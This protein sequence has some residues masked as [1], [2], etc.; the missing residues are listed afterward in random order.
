MT[1]SF[2]L[3]L[4][5]NQKGVS[6][7]KVS[8]RLSSQKTPPSSSNENLRDIETPEE[9]SVQLHRSTSSTTSDPL[10]DDALS[11]QY[12]SSPNNA[13]NSYSS[14]F[15]LLLKDSEQREKL[16]NILNTDHTEILEKWYETLKQENHN[17]KLTEIHLET[18]LSAIQENIR[19]T[20]SNDPVV[21]IAA[22]LRKELE[23]DSST[24]IDIQRSF[25]LLQEIVTT[26]LKCHKIQPHWVFAFDNFLREAIT[27]TSLL[28]TPGS[29]SAAESL[30]TPAT[31]TKSASCI[32]RSTS[33]NEAVQ[34][35]RD[36]IQ[37]LLKQLLDTLSSLHQTFIDWKMQ[38]EKHNSANSVGKLL[39]PSVAVDPQLVK[40][41]KQ[42]QVDEDTIKH[43]TYEEYSYI[44]FV[45]MVTLEELHGLNIKKGVVYRI[46]RSLTLLRKA[47]K[48]NSSSHGE[49]TTSVCGAENLDVDHKYDGS[50]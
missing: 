43:I 14:K 37:K 39:S 18:L 29:A 24:L 10:R 5:P 40:W 35:M 44:D 21:E 23:L 27:S 32:L 22:E 50:S 38:Q 3:F 12:P 19:C 33:T 26:R 6:W 28:L 16:L 7:N 34:Q 42:C 15:Y 30:S 17:T 1:F 48:I 2:S 45:E 20:A 31:S 36:E 49:N 9:S 46:W 4:V 8:T 13:T 41:L 25:C 47:K 11:S